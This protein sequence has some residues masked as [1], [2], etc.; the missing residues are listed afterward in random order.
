ML[1]ASL[2]VVALP[3]S[4]SVNQPPPYSS[5]GG[6]GWTRSKILPRSLVAQLRVAAN[7]SM[8]PCAGGATMCAFGTQMLMGE[9]ESN[10]WLWDS[11]SGVHAVDAKTL[12]PSLTL[13]VSTTTQLSSC[14]DISGDVLRVLTP[15]DAFGLTA[16]E[17]ASFST[18]NASLLSSVTVPAYQW[19]STTGR[20]YAAATCFASAPSGALPRQVWSVTMA[21]EQLRIFDR[22]VQVGGPRAL[23]AGCGLN[24]TVG[25]PILSDDARV[26]VV[27]ASC[28]SALP[29]TLVAYALNE[30]GALNKTAAQAEAGQVQDAVSPLWTYPIGFV[31]FSFSDYSPG[32][33]GGG[34]LLYQD[35]DA[36]KVGALEVGSGA[37]LWARALD[38]ASGGVLATNE[39]AAYVFTRSNCTVTAVRPM[40]GSLLWSYD[41]DGEGASC[42]VQTMYG[43][44]NPHDAGGLLFAFLNTGATLLIS[45]SAEGRLLQL[46]D[47]SAAVG[48][49]FLPPDGANM[50]LTSSGSLI[51]YLGGPGRLVRLALAE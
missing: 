17:Y 3:P 41:V 8:E 33:V 38:A 21:S 34:A 25:T 47:L 28:A 6:S 30:M 45:L 44:I 40:D 2:L 16:I 12:Q 18:R 27:Y 29:N 50:I 32:R 19:L 10:F 51:V 35:H 22:G 31:D 1:F 43:M 39:A 46:L 23:P 4:Q 15:H 9:D 48:L 49:A 24:G 20:R 7:V 26:L 14:F 42:R 37:R 11:T 13:P 5:F 36:L